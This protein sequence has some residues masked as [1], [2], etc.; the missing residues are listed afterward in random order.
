MPNTEQLLHQMTKIANRK[1]YSQKIR[2]IHR[3]KPVL[4][5]YRYAPLLEIDSNTGVFLLEKF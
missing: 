5:S 2:N 4:E 1:S 3:K